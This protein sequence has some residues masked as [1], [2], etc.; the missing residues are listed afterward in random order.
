MTDI[1]GLPD[2]WRKPTGSTDNDYDKGQNYCAAELEAALPTWTKITDD[3]DSKPP[4]NVPV[5]VA[6]PRDGAPF[7]NTFNGDWCLY[8]DDYSG[9]YIGSSWRPLIRGIDTPEDES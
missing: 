1:I 3:P 6:D 5:L 8:R 4:K 7:V 9:V 2:K